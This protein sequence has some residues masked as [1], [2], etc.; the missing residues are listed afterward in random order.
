MLDR[1]VIVPPPCSA[2]SKASPPVVR[3]V[4]VRSVSKTIA[5]SGGRTESTDDWDR[6]PDPGEGSEER[7]RREQARARVRDA[8]AGLPPRQREVVLLKVFSELTYREVAETLSLRHLVTFDSTTS[9]GLRVI[10]TVFSAI[11]GGI[12]ERGIAAQGIG[13]TFPALIERLVHG[14]AV[15]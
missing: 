8:V 1:F 13:I 15:P 14:A 12:F 10:M 5:A 9:Y 11:P 3:S 7:L 6:L 2:T 4:A